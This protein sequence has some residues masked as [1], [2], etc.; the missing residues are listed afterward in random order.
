MAA[1]CGGHIRLLG[2][3]IMYA[4]VGHVRTIQAPRDYTGMM[5]LIPCPIVDPSI[6]RLVSSVEHSR[7]PLRARSSFHL[8]SHHSLVK[9]WHG[10]AHPSSRVPRPSGGP[11]SALHAVRASPARGSPSH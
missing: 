6:C 9:H 7:A 5:G 8:P 2:R 3:S 4:H 1:A 10:T 11:P